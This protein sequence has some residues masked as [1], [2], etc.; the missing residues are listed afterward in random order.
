MFIITPLSIYTGNWFS[1][2]ISG[3][4]VTLHCWITF[5]RRTTIILTQKFVTSGGGLLRSMGVAFGAGSII[6]AQEVTRAVCLAGRGSLYSLCRR[7]DWFD[8]EE[9]RIKLD[10]QLNSIV[11]CG[12]NCWLTIA[13]FKAWGSSRTTASRFSLWG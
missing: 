7:V 5:S 12:M 4:G 2:A 1:G 13:A 11:R 6:S 10:I 9:P 3:L 8:G